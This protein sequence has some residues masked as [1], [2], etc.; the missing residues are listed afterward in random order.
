MR[1]RILAA[2]TALALSLPLAG[3]ALAGE[4]ADVERHGSCTNAS[5]WQLGAED[6][7]RYLEVDFEIKTS[8]S[9]QE[10]RIFLK[11][12]G[13]VFFRGVRTTATD[14]DVEVDR[15]VRDHAGSDRIVARGINL[16]TDEVCRGA[17]TI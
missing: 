13:N 10:W 7:G 9:G 4:G 2:F 17:L 6:E 15:H 14:G 12:D 11:R 1:F 8:R 5:A 3:T 16:V